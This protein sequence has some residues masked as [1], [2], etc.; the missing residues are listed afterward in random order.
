MLFL[1]FSLQRK[2]GETRSLGAARP[3]FS[4]M[5]AGVCCHSVDELGT[6]LAEA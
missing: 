1:R 6:Y 4:E 2:A 3:C 5:F